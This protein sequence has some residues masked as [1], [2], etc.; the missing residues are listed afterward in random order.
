[1]AG[2]KNSMIVFLC[3]M[4]VRIFAGKEAVDPLNERG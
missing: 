1:L 2:D 4:F 3:G